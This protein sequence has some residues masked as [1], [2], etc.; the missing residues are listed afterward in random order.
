MFNQTASSWVVLL[1]ALASAISL[2][3]CGGGEASEPVGPRASEDQRASNQALNAV[4]IPISESLLTLDMDESSLSESSASD[5]EPEPE[6]AAEPDVLFVASATVEE[7]ASATPDASAISS[8]D[9]PKVAATRLSGPGANLLEQHHLARFGFVV[10]GLSGTTT[11]MQT[12]I[13]TIRQRNPRIKLANYTNLVEANHQPISGSN[14]F[15]PSLAVIAN[16]WWTYTANGSL[17]AWTSAYDT[18]VVNI[19]KWAPT[20]AQGRRYPRW[21][22]DHQAARLGGLVGLDYIYTDNVWH[23]PRPRTGSADWRRIGTDQLNASAE[24]QS[25]HRQGTADYWNALRTNM[26]SK[27]IIGNA[28]NDLSFPEFK[29]QLNG[30]FLECGMGKSWS[31]ETRGWHLMMA[32]YRA[33]LANTIAPKDVILQGCGPNGL[34]L[35]Q[36]RYGLA[37]ALLED[38]WFAYNITGQK[39]PVW[40]D[41]YD[42]PLGSAIEA[43]PVAPTASGIW[44]RKYSNGLVV[45]NPTSTAAS[46][47]VGSGYRRLSGAQDPVTNN[48]QPVSSVTLGPRTGLLL[49]R[50]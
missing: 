19:T 5:A 42:A 21:L 44:M 1:G 47:S 27:M 38:G 13:N 34:N 36:L 46:I 31:L 20:D 32:Q 39:D 14:H 30:A 11:Q 3:G 35:N 2:S 37:S 12:I 24:I 22:A 43:P 50:Q 26:P 6:R 49:V 9:R 28:D 45:V 18:S 10:T 16:D 29:S 4:A 41:E 8:W 48:G 23:T 33:M 7:Q 17:V 25:A 40:A 15:D